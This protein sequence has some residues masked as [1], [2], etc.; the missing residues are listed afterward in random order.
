[1]RKILKTL[2]PLLEALEP[3]DWISGRAM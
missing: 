1:L 3:Q 2:D